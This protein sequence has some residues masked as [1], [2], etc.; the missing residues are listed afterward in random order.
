MTQV[1]QFE[2]PESRKEG[3]I[4]EGDEAD[5]VKKGLDLLVGGAQIFNIIIGK[6]LAL[7]KIQCS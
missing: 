7:K 6:I 5:T 3:Q 4:F 1:L 2:K